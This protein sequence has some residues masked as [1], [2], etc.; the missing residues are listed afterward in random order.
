LK[1][2]TRLLVIHSSVPEYIQLY[3]ESSRGSCHSI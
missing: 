2:L 1:K 3:S